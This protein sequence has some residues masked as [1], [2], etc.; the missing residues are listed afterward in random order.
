MMDVREEITENLNNAINGRVSLGYFNERTLF[1][2]NYE[3]GSYN[4]ILKVRYFKNG[5]EIQ[6]T[7]DEK[8]NDLQIESSVNYFKVKDVEETVD[9]IMNF[10]SKYMN[11]FSKS[12][13]TQ[14]VS[15]E[16]C[17]TSHH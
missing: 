8:K 3:V 17:R 7:Y 16:R 15:Q 5:S 6:M 11:G 14:F 9:T 2:L 12:L 13:Q 4:F 10:L 1:D